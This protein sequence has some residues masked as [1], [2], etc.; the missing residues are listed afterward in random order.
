MKNL[1]GLSRMKMKQEAEAKNYKDENE[2]TANVFFFLV[3]LSTR[4]GD[5]YIIRREEKVTLI[6][7]IPPLN[8]SEVESKKNH[9]SNS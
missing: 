2:N 9:S 1:E 4:N 6:F 8:N 7:H 5:F 3:F